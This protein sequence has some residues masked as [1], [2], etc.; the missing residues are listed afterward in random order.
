MPK[1]PAANH[2]L[3]EVLFFSLRFAVLAFIVWTN[4]EKLDATT[5]TILVTVMF[6]DGL[7]SGLRARALKNVSK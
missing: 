3:W 4:A 6:G 1:A 7:L 5:L 2:P